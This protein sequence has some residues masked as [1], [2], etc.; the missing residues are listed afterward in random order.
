MKNNI[1]KSAAQVTIFSTVEKCLS[2]VYRIILTRIIGAEGLGIYQICLTVFAVFLTAASSGVPITVSRL[3]AKSGAANDIRGKH[4]AVTA[5]IISTLFI[6]VPAA[7]ILFFGRN[8]FGFLFS[9]ERCT[10][11]FIILLPGLILTSVYAVIRGSFWGNKQFLPY[12]VIELLE[13]AIM[14]ICGV[15]LVFGISDPVIGARNAIIAVLISYV[16]SFVVSLFWYFRKGGRLVNPKPQLKPLISSATPITAMRT[17]TSLIN[18]AV[19]VIL[20]ALLVSACGYSNSDA[21]ALYGVVLGMAVPLIYAPNALIGSIAVVVAPELSENYYK[22][23]EEAVRY[24]VEKTVKAA[25]F[26]AAILVPLLFVLGGALSKFLY[27]SELCGKIV[28]LSSFMVLPTCIAMITNT[29]LNSMNCE[30]R[31]MLYFFIGAAVML[32][33]LIFLTKYLDV[34][35]YILGISLS[36]IICTVLNLRLLAKKCPKLRY[37]KYLIHALLVIAAACLFGWLL[38]GIIARYLAPVWQILICGPLIVAFTAG[39]LYCMEMFTM[40]PFKRLFAKRSK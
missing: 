14:V 38:N 2:F 8:A 12:S 36:Q 11:I 28:T 6:T 34:Y 22:K 10:E 7:I 21:I 17:S 3:M 39:T 19:A 5:G 4:S 31:T 32:F 1:Y 33:C 26:I 24:D 13:D 18:S 16:F 25:I 29:V 20:P 27:D 15:W 30:K 35:A 40:H 23:R 9:D 37:M